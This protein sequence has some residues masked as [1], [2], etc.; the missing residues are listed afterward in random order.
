MPSQQDCYSDEEIPAPIESFTSADLPI[1][2][3]PSPFHSEDS[4]SGSDSPYET[5]SS[6]QLATP[7]TSSTPSTYLGISFSYICF[8]SQTV[9]EEVFATPSKPMRKKYIRKPEH[10]FRKGN[11]PAVKHKIKDKSSSR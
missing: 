1:L 5:E 3:N 2:S 7:T 8:P 11:T 9:A 10:N 4:S 6:S